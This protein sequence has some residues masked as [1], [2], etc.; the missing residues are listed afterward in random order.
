MIDPVTALIAANLA[1]VGSHFAMSH[2]LRPIMVRVLG[3]NGFAG[4]YSLVSLACMVWVAQAFGAVGPGGA[5]LWDGT[6]DALWIV[7]SLLT[8]VALA[9]VIGALRGNPAMAGMGAGMGARAALKAEAK[10]VFA[11][12]RHPLLWGFAVW[13]VSHILIMPNPRT[14]VTAGAMGLLA[15][16]GAH[17]QDRK[18]RAQLGEAWAG[19]EAKTSFGLRIGKLSGIGLPLWL[20]ALAIWLAVTWLHGWQG[21]APAGIWRWLG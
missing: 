1:F 5:L 18:K 13:A 14:L 12:T 11:V 3:E 15:L 17:L 8:I 16:L 19:W 6:G 2:P 20:A 21:T 10:G 7:A 4:V 9:L